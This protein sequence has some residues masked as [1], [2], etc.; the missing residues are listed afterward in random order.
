[1]QKETEMR[2]ETETEVEKV[3]NRKGNKKGKKEN[4]LHY[5]HL[6]L[7]CYNIIIHRNRNEKWI[8][9]WSGKNKEKEI[10]K[11]GKDRNGNENK[12]VKRNRNEEVSWNGKRIQ[13]EKEKNIWE[14][15]WRS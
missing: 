1:M 13:N 3:R 11:K 15:K 5:F 8:G 12:D 6:F 9:N 7:F 10:R 2:I 14:G 4:I